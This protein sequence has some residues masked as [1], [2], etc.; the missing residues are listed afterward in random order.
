MTVARVSLPS[1]DAPAGITVP[2]PSAVQRR[3]GDVIVELGFATREKVDEAADLARRDGR[4]TG[5][6]LVETGTV[7]TVQLAQALA[8]RSGLP[9]VDLN[10]FETDRAAANLIAA[11]EAQRC[12]GVPIAFVDESTVLVATPNPANVVGF[13]DISMLTGYGVRIAVSPADH[14]DALVSQLEGLTGSVAEIAAADPPGDR[15]EVVD[16]MQSADEA[17]VI[18]LVNSLIADAVERGASDIHFDPH[19]GDMQIRFRVDGVVCDT[20]TVPRRLVP[21]VLSRIK[22]MAEL[23]IAEHRLPQDG[24][25]RLMVGERPIDARVTTLPVMRGE[26][27]VMRILD[28]SQLVPDLDGLGMEVGDREL[29]AAAIAR[30][31]GAVLVTG[32]TG[33]GKTTTLYAALSEINTPDRTMIAIEDP[34]EYELEGVKQVQVNAKSG[35]TFA[36]GLRSMI[37]SDPDVLMVGEIRDRET[38]RIAVESALTGHLVLSTMHTH[39]APMAPA[40]LIEMGIEPFLVASGIECVVAQRLVRRLCEECRQPVTLSASDLRRSGVDPEAREDIRA[41]EPAG[42]LRCKG[43]GYSGRTGIYEVIV[44]SPEIRD[45]ILRRESAAEISKAAVAAGMRRLRDDGLEKV[46]QGIT[47]VAELLRVLGT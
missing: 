39:D 45:L 7:N 28:H 41:H 20:T 27:L 32:P 16:L 21:G 2:T 14:F 44:M 37:R 40:R 22:V 8:E 35:L 31:H 38:A 1:G 11:K 18:K 9:Y 12:G 13:D 5:E 47:S 15:D 19:P 24:R 43:T 4:P 30:A 6:V 46:R 36:A 17:P 3:L 34:V 10:V 29:I 25:V 26:S 42:C 23:D 33:A